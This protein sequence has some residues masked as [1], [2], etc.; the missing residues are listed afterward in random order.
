[1]MT[2]WRFVCLRPVSPVQKEMQHSLRAGKGSVGGQEDGGVGKVVVI[3]RCQQC[4]HQTRQ[5]SCTDTSD[6]A[7]LQLADGV[8]GR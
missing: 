1:M 5:G 4:F 7:G 3:E 8:S 6:F 2:H